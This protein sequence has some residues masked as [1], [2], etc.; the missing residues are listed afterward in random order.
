MTTNETVTPPVKKSPPAPRHG[1]D[2]PT[3]VATLDVVRG[4]RDL[5][6][7]Q[8]RAKNRWLGGT[9]S[10]THIE[11]FHGAGGEH[12]HAREMAIDADHPQVLCGADQ[13]P[14][15]VEVLLHALASCLTAGIANIAAVRGVTLTAVD[16]QRFLSSRRS[17][18]GRPGAGCRRPPPRCRCYACRPCRPP[19]RPGQ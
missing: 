14:T 6:K 11:S 12:A 13:G 18:T 15:P 16:P 19:D 5:A 10:R 7:F 4:Q 2:T 1:V 17:R 9:H 3:L 8:F